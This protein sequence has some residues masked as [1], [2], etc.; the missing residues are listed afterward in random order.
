MLCSSCDSDVQN[1]AKLIESFLKGNIAK[2]V[3]EKLFQDSDV[4][5]VAFFSKPFE[6][7]PERILL[8]VGKGCK[9]ELFSIEK[10][11]NGPCC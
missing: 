10:V 1:P 3:S 9:V 6:F 4:H 11:F 8:F 7:S 2:V 5:E